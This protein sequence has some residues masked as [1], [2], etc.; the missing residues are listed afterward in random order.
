MNPSYYKRKER[1]ICDKAGGLS[2]FCKGSGSIL[3]AGVQSF[4]K[5]KRFITI[6]I[7][8]SRFLELIVHTDLY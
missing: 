5:A 8:I 2:F 6:N 7:S 3:T 1:P 4:G